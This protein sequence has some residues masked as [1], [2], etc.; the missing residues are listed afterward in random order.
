MH[1]AIAYDETCVSEAVR[2]VVEKDLECQVEIEI[3]RKPSLPKARL[4][5]KFK[6]IAREMFFCSLLRFNPKD[7][8]I[9][10]L[11]AC[12]NRECVAP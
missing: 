6:N 8:D 5:E 2:K 1:I 12:T 9:S 10:T 11:E 3:L 7:P 4:G